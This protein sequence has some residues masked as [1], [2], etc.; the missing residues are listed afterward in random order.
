MIVRSFG[1]L[2]VDTILVPDKDDG[3]YLFEVEPD[4]WVEDMIADQIRLIEERSAGL[5]TST[6]PMNRERLL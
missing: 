6:D 2:T 1:Y 3:W 5:R 4:P